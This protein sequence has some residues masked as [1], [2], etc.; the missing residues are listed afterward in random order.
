MND[1]DLLLGF[2][3]GG[4]VGASVVAGSLLAYKKYDLGDKAKIIKNELKRIKDEVT[5]SG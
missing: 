5:K 1:K 4:I 3:A 2:L